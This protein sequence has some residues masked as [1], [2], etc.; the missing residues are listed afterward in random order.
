MNRDIRTT[1]S[2]LRFMTLFTVVQSYS[3]SF[4]C[5]GAAEPGA[6]VNVGA[7]GL[8]CKPVDGVKV[9]D[10]SYTI[11]R[12]GVSH[13]TGSFLMADRSDSYSA[14]IGQLPVAADYSISLYA[15]AERSDNARAIECTGSGGFSVAARETTVVSVPLRCL[16]SREHDDS[17]NV[18][19][20]IDSAG[21]SS[22]E[23]PVG[24]SISL[25]GDAHDPDKTMKP[26][27]LAWTSS[28]GTLGNETGV[29]AELTCTDVGKLK[30]TLKISDGDDTCPEE[31]L[32]LYIECLPAPTTPAG[33]SGSG[34]TPTPWWERAGTGGIAN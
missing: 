33:A 5:G 29:L 23:T 3:L 6:D 4:G 19:P 10:V 30:V 17:L 1:A 16:G 15:M 34:G 21:V 9:G 18:C 24:S 27:E 7:L 8:Q 11:M 28:G 14:V 25:R 32:S 13:R 20:T 2:C 31:S 22:S 26:L 12:S